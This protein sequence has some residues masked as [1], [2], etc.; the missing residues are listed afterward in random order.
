M[1]AKRS[2]GARASAFT[3]ARSSGNEIVSRRRRA[4]GTGSLKRLAMIA[5]L[6]G[7]VN[8]GSPVSISYN[9]HPSPYT[10]LRPSSARSPAACSGLMYA[11]VPSTTPVRVRLTP[12]AASSAP[13]MPKSATI[14]SPPDRRMFSGLTSRW[15]TSW[16]WA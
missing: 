15:M 6:V 5:W 4:D 9:T 14:A 7:P 3:I 16:L 8:G 11:G 2:A 12:P 1:L 13:A 10:S